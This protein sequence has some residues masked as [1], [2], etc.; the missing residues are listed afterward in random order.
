VFD[1]KLAETALRREKKYIC[2]GSFF[3]GKVYWI[4]QHLECPCAWME[5]GKFLFGDGTDL[6]HLPNMITVLVDSPDYAIMAQKG[7]LRRGSPEE[8][9]HAAIFMCAEDVTRAQHDQTPLEANLPELLLLL[10]S[11]NG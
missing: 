3:F 8:P 6:T 11:R 7:A 2:G 5:L 4:P 9:C 10:R 1:S